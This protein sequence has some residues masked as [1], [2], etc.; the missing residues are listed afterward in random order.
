MT[1]RHKREKLAAKRAAR[2]IEYKPNPDLIRD[3]T[4]AHFVPVGITVATAV[5][6]D[7]T[8]RRAVGISIMSAED[9]AAM[10]TV[11]KRRASKPDEN[12]NFKEYATTRLNYSKKVGRNMALGRARAFNERGHARLT[13]V[14]SDASFREKLKDWRSLEAGL[15]FDQS[16]IPFLRYKILADVLGEDVVRKQHAQLFDISKK[17]LK[18]VSAPGFKPRP[19]TAFDVP[20]SKKLK[21]ARSKVSGVDELT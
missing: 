10:N 11:V 19:H 13:A 2:G 3:E 9:F 1:T 17:L 16:G 18:R 5:C 4:V 6:P 21:P 7:S 8:D 15:E 14:M 20:A 12:G